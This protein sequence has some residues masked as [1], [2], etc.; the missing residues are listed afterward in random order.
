MEPTTGGWGSNPF[1]RAVLAQLDTS[2]LTV[3]VSCGIRIA[4]EGCRLGRGGR[5]ASVMSLWTASH[6]RLGWSK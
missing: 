2:A 3:L 4:S 5:G 6:V 1:G